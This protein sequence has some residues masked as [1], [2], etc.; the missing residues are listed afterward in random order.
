MKKLEK[1]KWLWSSL[2]D[3]YRN[4]NNFTDFEQK[5]RKVCKKHNVSVYDTGTSQDDLIHLPKQAD[6]YEA[7]GLGFVRDKDLEG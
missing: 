5:M 3:H 1:C 4:T 6:F 7:Y 2:E